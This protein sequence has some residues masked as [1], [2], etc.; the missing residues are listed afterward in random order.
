MYFLGLEAIRISEPLRVA[1]EIGLIFLTLFGTYLFLK[2]TGGVS[3]L[4]GMIT[5]IVLYV[6]FM[7]T[8]AMFFKLYRILYILQSIVG[9]LIISVLIIFQPEVRRGL[10]R[11]SQTRFWGKFFGTETSEIIEVIVSA[12]T[13]MA[14]NKIGALIVLEK[15]VSLAPFIERG[16]PLDSKL[17]TELL[18]TIFYK[19]TP[20][21]DGAVII[22]NG[23][24]VAAACVLPLSENPNLPRRIGTRHRAAI[25][26]SEQSDALAIIVSEETGLISTALDGKLVRGIDKVALQ[27]V[28]AKFFKEKEEITAQT[29][30]TQ[31]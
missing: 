13:K 27:A 14:Q 23:R 1:I 7:L 28:L 25:G 11:I 5:L 24:I 2:K 3:I 4:K 17:T 16:V 22:R 18:N 20:L 29:E 10:I 15:G 6:F 9:Y 8:L 19:G 21:H 30:L 12:V 26:I 31:S